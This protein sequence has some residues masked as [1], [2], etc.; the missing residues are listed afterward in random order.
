MNAAYA[1][2]KLAPKSLS[3]DGVGFG[4]KKPDTPDI[5]GALGFKNPRTKKKIA[6][7]VE[8]MARYKYVFD[9]SCFI[10]L[11][12]NLVK[13]FTKTTLKPE[14]LENMCR[15]AVLNYKHVLLKFNNRTGA[16]E[17]YELKNAQ[18]AALIGIERQSFTQTHRRLYDDMYDHLVSLDCAVTEHINATMVDE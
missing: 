15:S 8:A 14:T 17:R 1:L 13:T 18:L 12:E 16:Q 9:D 2:S 5:N 11:V 4:N 7:E 6:A 3:I 10:Q